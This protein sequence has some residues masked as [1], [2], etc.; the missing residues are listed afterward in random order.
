MTMVARVEQP[1]VPLASRSR[2]TSSVQS[3]VVRW[4][5][6]KKKGKKA[7]RS[8]QR[9]KK[10]EKGEKNLE[11]NGDD[12]EQG[13]CASEKPETKSVAADEKI[14]RGCVRCADSEKFAGGPILLCSPEAQLSK[15]F[16]RRS[17]QSDDE[18]DATASK[19][20]REKEK[21]RKKEGSF[22]HAAGL[23]RGKTK[24]ETKL[25]E[26]DKAPEK[27][28]P[29]TS[30]KFPRASREMTSFELNCLLIDLSVV[31]LLFDF[32]GSSGPAAF[33]ALIAVAAHLPRLSSPRLASPGR[34]SQPWSQ[35]SVI[36]NHLNLI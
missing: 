7:P 29:T 35:A 8:E 19:E 24:R 22:L 31:P 15:R 2:C 12:E 30:L 34:S 11:C 17:L 3:P 26:R 32:S 5:E 4:N 18:C 14:T 25:L 21:K 13:A 28:G 9:G 1:P 10:V 36:V 27:K 20:D 33:L 23:K 6:R 16:G